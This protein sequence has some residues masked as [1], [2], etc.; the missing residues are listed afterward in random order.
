MEKFW[1]NW[2]YNCLQSRKKFL[3]Q[4]PSTPCIYHFLYFLKLKVFKSAV[5]GGCVLP[6]YRSD[7]SPQQMLPYARRLILCFRQNGIIF[8]S[9]LLSIIEYW[10]WFDR[11]CI[12]ESTMIFMRP[13]SKFVSFPCFSF[14][15]LTENQLT[16]SG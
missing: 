3:E 5:D 8:T 13:V 14:P 6:K 10:T 4:I 12:P 9:G 7:I 16:A 2:L 15:T 1:T 11:I